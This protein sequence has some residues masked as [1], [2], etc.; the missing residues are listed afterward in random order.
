MAELKRKLKKFLRIAVIVCIVLVALYLAGAIWVAVT[1]TLSQEELQQEITSEIT[2]RVQTVFDEELNAQVESCQ[3]EFPEFRLAQPPAFS[4]EYYNRWF[5][6]EGHATG[7]IDILIDCP[8]LYPFLEK[9]S[10]RY[11]DLLALDE[12][13][14]ALEEKLCYRRLP[15]PVVII[16]ANYY[17]WFESGRRFV[18]LD[19]EGNEY[20]SS[21]LAWDGYYD[22]NIKK[23]GEEVASF[24]RSSGSGGAGSCYWCG[25]TGKVK[26][27]Y[28][29]SDLEAIL[30][31]HDPYTYGTCGS[32]GGTGRAK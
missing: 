1:K 26:Y 11:E 28:G 7:D 27:N 31:G 20:T 21:L 16:V 30:S 19:S 6:R 4:L 22:G 23:N 9:D 2:Q 5:V 18:Y 17:C 8:A 12:V 10:Y 32:C 29:S 25:G 13:R 15:G 24:H 14:S 3:V